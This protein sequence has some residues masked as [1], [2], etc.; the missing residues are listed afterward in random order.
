MPLNVPPRTTHGSFM[1]SEVH[2]DFDTLDADIAILGLPYGSAYWPEA[3]VNDQINAPNAVRQASY[4][5]CQDLDRYDYDLGGP[6]F[7]NRPVKMVDVG[8]V[9][10]DISVPGGDHFRRAEIVMRKI[11]KSGALPI[12]IGGDHGIP[13][14]IFRAL[15]ELDPDGG[16]ITLIQVDAHID[17]RNERNGV[18][19]GLSSPIRR[20]SELDHIGDIFQIGMRA[21]GSARPEEV[22]AA[23]AYGANIITSF[24]VQQLGIQAILDRIPDKGRYYITIDADGLDPSICPAVETPCPGGLSYFQV[25]DLIHGLVRK[26]R[27]VGMDIVEICPEL[28]LNDLTSVVACRLIT[29]LIGAATRADYFGR[30]NG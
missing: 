27:V 1:F 6:I 18:H 9:R 8:D 16:Q 24:E 10:Y 21:Q 13:I 28:D 15:E 19:D 5:A 17:W 12:T 23:A 4:R 20:A 3:I 11:L 14:P 25:R 30:D 2:T 29:N 26:G 22:E 7:D